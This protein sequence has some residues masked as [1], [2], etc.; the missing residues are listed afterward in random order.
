MNDLIFAFTNDLKFYIHLSYLF[1]LI[2]AQI[3]A[4]IY[5]KRRKGIYWRIPIVLIIYFFAVMF[6]PADLFGV[7]IGVSI[8]TLTMFLLTIL[9]SYFLF[10][11]S[12]KNAIIIGMGTVF[13]QHAGMLTYRI[14]QRLI[15][16]NDE[17][18]SGGIAFLGPFKYSIIYYVGYAISYSLSY[19]LILRKLKNYSVENYKNW[20]LIILLLGIV[21]VVYSIS[22]LA[23]RTKVNTSLTYLV[24]A[25]LASYSLLFILFSTGRHNKMEEDEKLL[26]QLLAQEQKHY[27][28]IS[29]SMEVVNRRCHDLKYQV[30]YLRDAESLKRKEVADQLQKDVAIY[31]GFIKTGN[32]SLDNVISEKHLVCDYK[33]IKFNY[34]IENSIN[35]MEPV[36]LYVLLGNAIDNAIECVSYYEEPYRLINISIKQKNNLVFIKISNP[37][38]NNIKIKDNYP[39]TSKQDKNLHGFG[40]KSMHLIVEKYDGNIIETLSDNHFNVEIIFYLK[41]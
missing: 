29:I 4:S 3:L 7:Y 33:N 32:I 28:Q 24:P 6:I 17:L 9:S 10:D 13:T 16:I 11:I 23:N 2:I 22:D 27:E 31:E 14:I 26:K 36:D 39:L 21:I 1:T 18:P 25:A 12:F 41:N 37:C 5:L 19:F 34:I 40:I 38:F 35:F 15:F 8:N 20:Q 30:E